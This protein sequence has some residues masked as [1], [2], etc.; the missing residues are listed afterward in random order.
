MMRRF[1]SSPKPASRVARITSSALGASMPSGYP[2]AVAHGV[3]AGQ[4]AGRLGREDQVVGRQRVHE[5]RARHLDELGAG[6]D[7]QVDRLLE[8]GEHAGLV[9]LAAELLDHA[10]A[11]AGEVAVGAAP[12]GARPGRAAAASMDVESSGSWPPMI[13]CSRAASRTVRV[14]GPGLVEGVGQR[15]E[16]VARHP[17]VRRLHPDR[18]GDGARLADRAAGVGADGQRRLVRRH[19]RGR[20]AAGAAG[21]AVEVP[22]VAR[23]PVGR[24]LGGGAHRELVHVGLAQDRQARRA[25]ARDDGGVVRRDPALEDPRAAR[26][27]QALGGHHVLDRDRDAVERRSAAG[28]RRGARRRR[29]PARARPRRRRAGRRA[30]APSTSAIRSR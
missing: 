12:G 21:D 23:R 27:G 13:S 11:H 30:P 25:E 18:A 26:R 14:T 8:A 3:E 7:H 9:A 5:V 1:T 20:A 2:Q 19:G 17:A 29:R 24:V 4:V 22:R 10:D 28:P 15:D 16:P 6:R